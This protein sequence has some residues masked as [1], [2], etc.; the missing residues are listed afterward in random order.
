MSG[1]GTGLLT[2]GTAA[3][4][5]SIVS[6]VI[7]T[8]TINSQANTF[9]YFT[10]T[11]ANAL[12]LPSMLVF[13]VANTSNPALKRNGATFEDRLGDD[14]GF[15]ARQSFYDRFGSGSPEGVVSA[16][17]GAVYHRTDGGAV[18]SFYVKESGSTGNTGWVAK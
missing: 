9:G 14:S 7:R 12:Y 13:N 3:G 1:S 15:A 16:P 18:T 5:G 17:V 2:V 10:L 8:A 4:T 11:A 6:G